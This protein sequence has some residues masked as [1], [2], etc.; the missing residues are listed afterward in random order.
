MV[1]Q[2]EHRLS[3]EDFLERHRVVVYLFLGLFI[4]L[5]V[6]LFHLQ[7]ILGRYYLDIS[8]KQRTHIILKRAPRGVIYDCN[9]N[10]IVGN[11]TTFVALFYPFS[12]NIMPTPV[13]LKRLESILD[14]KNLTVIMTQGLRTGK[15]VR[16]A[17]NLTRFEM[18]KLQEQRLVFPG[19]SVVNE[20]RRDYR[21]PL[22]NSHLAGY[23]NEISKKE[24]EALRDDGFKMGD[25]IGRGGIEQTYDNY[26]RGQD[27]GWE[28]EVDA[29]GHQTQLV[30]H[31]PPV[32][33]NSVYSTVDVKLQEAAS[34]ALRMT[35]TGRGAVMAVDPRTGAVKCFVSSPGFDPNISMMP[36]FGKYLTDKNLPLWD[37][38]DQARY[39]PGSIF[40]IITF[41]AALEGNKINPSQT[42]NCTGSFMFGNKSFACWNKKGHGRVD[43]MQALSVSCNVYFYQ[44]GLKV[45]PELIEKYAK[46]FR[47]GEITGIDMPS[48]KRGLVPSPEWKK[49]RVG[50]AWHPGD[51][52]NMAIGQ[53]SLWVTPAQMAMMISAVANGGVI[54]K[55]YLV[56]K[57]LN[58]NGENVLKPQNKKIGN[59]ELSKQTWDMLH[60]GL[61]SVVKDGTARACYFENLAVAGKTGTAQ[62]PQGKDHGWFVAYAPADNPEL[63]VAVIVENGGG[64]GAVAA[65]VA[66]EIFSAAFKHKDAKRVEIQN[67]DEIGN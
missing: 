4:L 65:P 31:V 15:A 33:G 2:Q 56:D 23:V 53:G 1:W 61:K 3:Y 50:E 14:M 8:E 39:P 10:V 43:L 60:E 42:F 34:R 45:G 21:S 19:I 22:A 9:G 29:T 67:A 16:L 30:R 59:I 64:G 46:L 52:I 54:Y 24:L 55:P 13:M 44:L 38:I 36:E 5:A 27:G 66:R 6:R 11:R 28:I 58:V 47:I 17:E 62:N 51:T 41:I 37:R 40:K 49:K 57:I 7:I 25:W 20:V 35:A 48:E 12:Q 32:T 18:L 63:A 26:L